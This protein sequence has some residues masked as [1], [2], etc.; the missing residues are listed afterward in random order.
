MQHLATHG[1]TTEPPACAALLPRRLE[2]GIDGTSGGGGTGSFASSIFFSLWLRS[3]API[4]D[5]T[6][7]CMVVGAYDCKA[8]AEW[9]CI[10]VVAICPG[11]RIIISEHRCDHMSP[12]LI[13][14]VAMSAI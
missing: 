6:L 2:R 9:D 3:S 4:I 10:A 8:F 12:L 11:F 13:A 14:L 1:V 7:D 5:D